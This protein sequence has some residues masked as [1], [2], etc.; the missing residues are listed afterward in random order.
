MSI[1]GRWA[2]GIACAA[3]VQAF[4]LWAGVLE[5]RWPDTNPSGACHA[6]TLQQCITAAPAHARVRVV[7][8]LGTH[9]DYHAIPATLTISRPLE[10]VVDPGIDAVLAQGAG[11]V[12]SPGS[13]QGGDVRIEGFVIPRGSI[14]VL[15]VDA[16][17]GVVRIA[18]NR[19]GIPAAAPSEAA[20]RLELQ[21][22]VAG[23][24][25]VEIAENVLYSTGNDGAWAIRI[26]QPIS[27]PHQAEVMVRDNV[28]ESNHP[29]GMRQGMTLDVARATRIDIER[30]IVRGSTDVDFASRD[31][32]SVV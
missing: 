30:N 18:R 28:I 8:G 2:F 9:G 32:K 29:E 10:V 17:P 23:L 16:T 25:R 13:G 20:I 15:P 3:A 31:R 11:I 21:A 5:L 22:N 14:R 6:L 4:P 7:R 19:I 26:L 24:W 1:C 27:G 12:F